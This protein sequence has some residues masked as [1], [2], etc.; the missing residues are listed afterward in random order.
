[1]EKA[2][3][4]KSDGSREL[5][6]FEISESY[7]LLSGAVGGYI[8]C[9]NLPSQ[10][11]AMWINEEGKLIGLPQNPIGTALWADEYGVTDVIMGDIILTSGTITPDGDTLGLDDKQVEL[12]MDY[13]R[14]VSLLF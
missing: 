13:N 11:V 5:V 1:M 10:N 7:K 3:I 4:I 6:S 9:V 2:I 14:Q 8:E 12:L